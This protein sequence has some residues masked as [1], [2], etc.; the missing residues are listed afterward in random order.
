MPVLQDIVLAPYGIFPAVEQA[1]AE[2]D[3]RL[4]ITAKSYDEYVIG[5]MD[6]TA[7]A[8]DNTMMIAQQRVEMEGLT[9]YLREVIE[10]HLKLSFAEV[11]AA[12]GA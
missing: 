5:M 9:P 8:G 11:Q 10:D 3:D 1:L 12:R 7:K 4:K 6:A 2:Q